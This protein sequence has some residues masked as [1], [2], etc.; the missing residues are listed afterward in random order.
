MSQG[1]EKV[2]QDLWGKPVAEVWDYL[3]ASNQ[4]NYPG[5]ECFI[6]CLAVLRAQVESDC[7]MKAAL[8]YNASS[9]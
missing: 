9:N 4:L 8:V 3:L 6:A 5:W 1:Y 7:T 2:L